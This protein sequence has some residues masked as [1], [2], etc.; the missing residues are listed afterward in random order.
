MNEMETQTDERITALEMKIA[1]L[2]DF[3]QQIQQVA[4]EQ[5]QTIN[6]IQKENKLIAEKMREMSDSLE[7]DIPNRKPPHY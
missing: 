1:W 6:R 3:V 5:A 7:G 4:V 2:E